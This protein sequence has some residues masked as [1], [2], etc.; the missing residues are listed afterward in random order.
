[1]EGVLQG[2]P[3]LSF[4]LESA[5]VDLE[6]KMGPMRKMPQLG[7]SAFPYPYHRGSNPVDV[8]GARHRGAEVDLWPLSARVT[9]R[10]TVEPKTEDPGPKC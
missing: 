2:A 4:C 8:L 5:A 3:P 9:L 10:A 1:M 6:L 7:E